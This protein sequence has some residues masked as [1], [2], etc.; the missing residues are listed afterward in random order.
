VIN[1]AELLDTIRKSFDGPPSSVFDR[2]L[3]S[4]LLVLDDV[5]QEKGT[6]W[7]WERLYILINTR[8]ENLR[9]TIFTTNLKPSE[10]ENRWG[11]AITS[12]ILG[13]STVIEL[14]GVDYRTLKQ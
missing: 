11:G 7:V 2:S 5:G 13:M 6:P 10:W 4:P 8:Y 9:P 14:K 3:N 12:R 1:C